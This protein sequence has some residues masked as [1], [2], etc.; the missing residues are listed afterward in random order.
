M[1]RGDSSA[2]HERVGGGDWAQ[3]EESLIPCSSERRSQWSTHGTEH[4]M[5]T[6]LRQELIPFFV[7]AAML[8]RPNRIESAPAFAPIKSRIQQ[9]LKRR[10]RR[11]AVEINL[12]LVDDLRRQ[13][14]EIP[15]ILGREH[16]PL[17]TRVHR[18]PQFVTQPLDSA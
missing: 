1:R 13:L 5:T 7:C 15:S 18:D 4:R 12:Q 16:R 17:G 3:A 10:L 6:R 14:R 8:R 11:V 2:I 9:S